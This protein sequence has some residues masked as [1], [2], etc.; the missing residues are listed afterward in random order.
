MT[1]CSMRWFLMALCMLWMLTGCDKPGASASNL[2]HSV[3][4][5]TSVNSSQVLQSDVIDG[6]YSTDDPITVSFTSETHDIADIRPTEF[7]DTSALDTVTF[8][9]YHVSHIRSDG[10]SNPADFTMG[11]HLVIPPKTSNHDVQ[12]VVVR[13]FDKERSPLMELRDNGQIVT[14]TILTFY[15]EDGYGNDV[16]V[17]GTLIIS[18]GNFF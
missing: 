11:T 2:T 10:G 4:T 3:I 16:V 17:S 1:F 9:S 14:T 13:A 6:G 8:S 5:I 12:I 18:F 15:G 7:S